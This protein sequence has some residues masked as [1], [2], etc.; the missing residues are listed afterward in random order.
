MPDFWKFQ[1]RLELG[2]LAECLAMSSADVEGGELPTVEKVDMSFELEKL[3]S[4][5]A[6]SDSL[7]TAAELVTSWTSRRGGSLDADLIQQIHEPLALLP[8][9]V[10]SDAGFWSWLACSYGRSFVWCRWSTAKNPPEDLDTVSE[11]LA[12]GET[13]FRFQMKGGLAG[14]S[15]HALARY[16]WL[17]DSLEGDY[18]LAGRIIRNQDIFQAIYE[19]EVGIVPH[20]PKALVEVFD[21]GT[22]NAPGGEAFREIVMKTIQQLSVVTRIETLDYERT[23]ELVLKVKDEKPLS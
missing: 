21:I 1:R 16:W 6:V 10:A 12:V 15:R 5:D 4:I 23:K 2:E 20:L 8:Q 19:R 18:E 17:A 13:R 3:V 22:E 9:P 7:E 11:L 14:V